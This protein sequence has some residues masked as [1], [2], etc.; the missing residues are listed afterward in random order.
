MRDTAA[1]FEQGLPRL[2]RGVANRGEHPN[3]GNYDSAGNKRSPLMPFTRLANAGQPGDMAEYPNR[4]AR[5]AFPGWQ[6]P[7]RAISSCL[8]YK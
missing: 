7:G 5:C 1:G 3:P 2:L 6:C 4:C 8:Q